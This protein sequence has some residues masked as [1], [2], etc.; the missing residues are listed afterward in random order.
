M[1]N[2]AAIKLFKQIAIFGGMIASPITV[3]FFIYWNFFS[4]N[5]TDQLNVK[6]FFTEP[7]ILFILVVCTFS[8]FAGVS[9]FRR[10]F[11]WFGGNK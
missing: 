2:E 9:Y 8:F 6:E 7:S 4:K 5:A 11:G 3:I 10:Q 1:D